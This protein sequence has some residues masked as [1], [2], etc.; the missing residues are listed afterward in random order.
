MTFALPAIQQRP[1][2]CCSSITTGLVLHLPGYL[3]LIDD[4]KIIS[5]NS[6]VVCSMASHTIIRKRSTLTLR[7]LDAQRSALGAGVVLSC[8]RPQGTYS[9]ASE[10]L[11]AFLCCF[12]VYIHLGILVDGLLYPCRS[13]TDV[14]ILVAHRRTFISLSDRQ[15]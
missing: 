2:G 10:I 15:H 13:A 1:R 5:I 9:F 14:H 7:L 11:R 12:I 8:Y 3:P 4:P 6:I